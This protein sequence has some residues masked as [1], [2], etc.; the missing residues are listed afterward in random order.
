MSSGTTPSGADSRHTRPAPATAGDGTPSH[1]LP[2]GVDSPCC[3]D[4]AER[5]WEFLDAE[6]PA[7]SS[8]EVEQHLARCQQ[9]YP[10]FDFQ[11]AYR[12][13]MRRHADCPVPPGLRSRVFRALLECE[14]GRKL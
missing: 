3:S 9:C 2:S 14:A 10:L 11:R 12:D 1:D 5:L 7:A 4:V 6:L 8:R 13:F